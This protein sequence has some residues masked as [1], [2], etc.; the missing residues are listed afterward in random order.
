MKI[1]MKKLSFY[2][3][4]CLVI[5]M[6]GCAA[7]IASHVSNPKMHLSDQ[8]KKIA[9]VSNGASSQSITTSNLFENQLSHT[10]IMNGSSQVQMAAES[11]SFEC[12]K[13]GFSVVS[14]SEN[15]DLLLELSIGSIRFDPL[16]GWIA[17][18]ANIKLRDANS[19]QLVASF[20]A[21]AGFITP[22]VDNMISK[23]TYEIK[24]NY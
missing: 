8:Y 9:I 2:A 4:T 23:L 11:L 18:Q 1:S 22:T 13:L 12:E 15:P 16:V 19:K 24:K 6:Q 10:Q 5:L 20:Q 21:K 17:D 14:I 7:H 3:M